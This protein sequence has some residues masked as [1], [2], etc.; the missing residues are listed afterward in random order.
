MC[1]GEDGM[2]LHGTVLLIRRPVGTGLGVEP[3]AGTA[4]LVWAGDVGR[5]RRVG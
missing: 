1:R 5:R 3:C 2:A 4:V